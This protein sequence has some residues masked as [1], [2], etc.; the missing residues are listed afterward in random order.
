MKNSEETP[1]VARLLKSVNAKILAGAGGQKGR[2][3]TVRGK[4][5]NVNQQT[6]YDEI[7][8]F[9]SVSNR[10]AG[11]QIADQS[12]QESLGTIQL[13]AE[14]LDNPDLSPGER[15]NLV[16]YLDV[17]KEQLD[18][19]DTEGMNKEDKKAYQDLVSDVES[20]ISNFR[21]LAKE[22]KRSYDGTKS[23]IEDRAA[24][25]TSLLIGALTK[26]PALMIAHTMFAGYRKEKKAA[27]QKQQ[28]H[29]NEGLRQRK[30]TLEQ[31]K[32]N[33][34]GSPTAVP[35]STVDFDTSDYDDNSAGFAST[36]DQDEKLDEIIKYTKETSEQ[37]ASL[38]EHSPKGEVVEHTEATSE[39]VSSLVKT[40]EK[41]NK[42]DKNQDRIDRENQIEDRR[43]P[44]AG[45]KAIKGKKGALKKRRG[46][47]DEDGFGL[48]DAAAL[49][50]T[51]GGVGAIGGLMKKGKVM[52]KMMTS[53]GGLMK[54]GGM[55]LKPLG[56]FIRMLGPIGLV[57]SGLLAAFDGFMNVFEHWNESEG[58]NMPDRLLSAAGD[59][60][61][62]IVDSLIGIFADDG[63]A[64]RKNL[65]RGVNEFF[66]NIADWLSDAITGI[67]DTVQDWFAG[68]FAGKLM[69][70]ETAKEQMSAGESRQ[71]Q[72]GVDAIVE[73]NEQVQERGFFSKLVKGGEIM[74]KEDAD[75]STMNSNNLNDL[76]TDPRLNNDDKS[77]IAAELLSRGDMNIERNVKTQSSVNRSPVNEYAQPSVPGEF[78][79]YSQPEIGSS[80]KD[81]V[82]QIIP[83]L[84]KAQAG[85][86][87]LNNE[88]IQEKASNFVEQSSQSPV[89]NNFTNNSQ[90]VINRQQMMPDTTSRGDTL[91]AYGING[92]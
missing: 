41:D 31:E 4:E 5:Q 40:I 77:A 67:L 86:I 29:L 59:F 37:L 12:I 72:R 82:Q 64:W 14:Q 27:A 91:R 30:K 8:R 7:D 71:R 39:K 44:S 88:I 13:V 62:G 89:I 53:F 23:F 19:G 26:N 51:I 45:M 69:G 50:L 78:S 90:G 65:V 10:I 2:T 17:A 74:L 42:H 3:R 66:E 43:K 80:A 83:S 34:G 18:M 25:A 73:D 84:A 85:S 20:E 87:G 81:Y 36:V 57:I 58:R 32:T 48:M 16:G 63:E 52:L 21:D 35:K 46:S 56:L 15:K 11:S 61:N 6:I 55:I 49:G 79:D 33:P 54:L 60:V 92:Q 28:D 22:G 38:V 47:D 9:E 76:Y 24:D 1:E 75:L 68:T 70:V